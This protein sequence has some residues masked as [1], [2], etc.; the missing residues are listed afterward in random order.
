MPDTLSQALRDWQNFYILV[1]GAS[2]TLAGLMFV[3]I[4]LGSTLI[5]RKDIPA[6]RVF[7]SPT[8]IHFVYVLATSA[9]V[10]IPIVTRTSLGVMLLLAGIVSLGWTLSTQPQMR[11][12]DRPGDIDAHDWIWYLVA[13]SAA[14]LLYIGTGIALLGGPGRPWTDW[15][16]PA[17]SCW[18]PASG[19]GGTW[20]RS[21]H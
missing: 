20:S 13:P 19:M 5:T 6:L 15:R 10:L 1:G 12:S 17:S 2:A 4:S 18:R 11:R 7:V 21:L 3:A 9:V 16:S 8:L 14:Y